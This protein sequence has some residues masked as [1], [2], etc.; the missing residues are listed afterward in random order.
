MSD[1][2][3]KAVD[4]VSRKH[5]ID[6]AQ[7]FLFACEWVKIQMKPFT[8]EHLKKAY[9]EAN[10][11]EPIQPNIFGS[12]FYNLSKQDRITEHGAQKARLK[13]AKGRLLRTWISREYR[14]KQRG[15]RLTPYASQTNLNL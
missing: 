14:L 6:Y 2:L 13:V 7:L 15:N 12:V 4:A 5:S 9:Y 8:S 1:D 11:P 3:Q 10:Y